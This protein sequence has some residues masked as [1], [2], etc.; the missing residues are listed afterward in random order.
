MTFSFFQN[1][2]LNEMAT[3][4]T[5][6]IIP[7]LF[8][9]SVWFLRATKVSIL[10]SNRYLSMNL[11]KKKFKSNKFP[12]SHITRS[13][14]DILTNYAQ[15]LF[16][17][18]MIFYLFNVISLMLYLMKLFFCTL[19]PR[20]VWNKIVNFHVVICRGF[21]DTSAS[22]NFKSTLATTHGFTRDYR[23]LGDTS[24][25]GGGFRYYTYR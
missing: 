21:S 12:L 16:I 2:S 23:H 9:K 13:A 1:V 25:S 20:V 15:K 6:Y 3:S 19:L 4:A 10:L 11:R 22:T 8:H 17:F 5:L 18:G 24:T 7:K 14:T